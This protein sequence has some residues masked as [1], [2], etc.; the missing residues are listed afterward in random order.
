M[1]DSVNITDLKNLLKHPFPP[2]LIDVRRKNDYIATSNKIRGAIWR[3]PEMINKWS[4]ELSVGRKIVV[5]C[6]NGGSV[7]QSVIERLEMEGHD[8]VFLEGGIKAW[9]DSG[10]P[11]E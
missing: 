9:V 10:E 3:D 8:A 1:T 2:L 5:Y 11:V 4:E 7:S 6:V